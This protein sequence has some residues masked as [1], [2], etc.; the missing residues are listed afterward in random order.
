MSWLQESWRM[1]WQLKK[2]MKRQTKKTMREDSLNA[3]ATARH[4]VS[5]DVYIWRRQDEGTW[6]GTFLEIA[7]CRELICRS[8]GDCKMQSD[9]LI[10]GIYSTE[11]RKGKQERTCTVR[12]VCWWIQPLLSLSVILYARIFRLIQWAPV[13]LVDRCIGNNIA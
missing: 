10:I 9:D 5:I 6:S 2:C 13:S 7:K 11:L 12:Q 4:D 8:I 3:C 1:L